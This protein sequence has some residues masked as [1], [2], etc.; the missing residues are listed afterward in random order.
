MLVFHFFVPYV[1]VFHFLALSDPDILGCLAQTGGAW[2][3]PQ[4]HLCHRLLSRIFNIRLNCI[5][6][7]IVQKSKPSVFLGEAGKITHL[8][9]TLPQYCGPGEAKYLLKWCRMNNSYFYLRLGV[10]L[11][12]I[13]FPF[14]I[15]CSLS[16]FFLSLFTFTFYI[17]IP[18]WNNWLACHAYLLSIWRTT[19]SSSSQTSIPG[20][21][22]WGED[23]WIRKENE[24][25]KK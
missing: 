1:P 3:Q 12:T 23:L 17:I 21:A 8:P 5:L 6:M 11:I 14:F 7:W 10:P 25:D 2:L 13:T 4:Q 24:K 19:T 20:L 16:L 15:Y 18:R 9:Y 22:R